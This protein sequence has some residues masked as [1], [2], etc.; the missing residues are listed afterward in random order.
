MSCGV[1]REDGGGGDSHEPRAS[2]VEERRPMAKV[3]TAA[4]LVK[5]WTIIVVL[6]M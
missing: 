4:T 1:D 5:R 2:A 6:Y 3:A